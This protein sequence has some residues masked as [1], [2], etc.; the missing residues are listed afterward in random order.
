MDTIAV[1]SN[2]L[3][4]VQLIEIIYRGITSFIY[5]VDS[6]IVILGSLHR[7]TRVEYRC[8]ASSATFYA[9]IFSIYGPKG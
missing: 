8:L 9:D 4:L 5:F 6:E 2:G 1:S 7:E 3:K